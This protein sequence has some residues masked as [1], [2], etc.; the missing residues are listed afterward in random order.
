MANGGAPRRGAP[1]VAEVADEGSLVDCHRCGGAR[2]RQQ[3]G[4]HEQRLQ[5]QPS[6]MVR[7]SPRRPA[8]GEDETQLT[9]S[10]A[11]RIATN[12][13][14]CRRCCRGSAVL[15][16]GPDSYFARPPNPDLRFGRALVVPNGN[17][18]ADALAG[19]RSSR[20]GVLAPVSKAME[21]GAGPAHVHLGF[22][23]PVVDLLSTSGASVPTK[24]LTVMYRSQ[25]EKGPGHVRNRGQV[26]HA[27]NPA[28]KN[29]IGRAET[30]A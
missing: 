15:L 2:G 20:N 30:L 6:R 24:V 9:K 4:D 14:S 13:A 18:Y 7:S 21:R 5:E 25:S 17:D 1:Q 23:Q 12:M 22:G 26:V 11:R 28:P 3:L 27:T 8:P 29:K 10:C 19:N 16:P